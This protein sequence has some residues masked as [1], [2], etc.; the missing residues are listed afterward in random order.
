[1]LCSAPVALWS[2]PARS[3]A[4][5]SSTSASASTTTTSPGRCSAPAA[6]RFPSASMREPPGRARRSPMSRRPCVTPTGSSGAQ[7]RSSTSS[8]VSRKHG[9]TVAVTDELRPI[10]SDFNGGG[11]TV[12]VDWLRLSPYASSSSFESRVFDAGSTVGWQT[13]AWQAQTPQG[14]SLGLNVRAGDTATPDAHVE[15]LEAGRRLGRHHRPGRPL[16]PVPGGARDHR[17]RTEPRSSSR[18]PSRPARRRSTRRP[19]RP[20]TATRSRRTAR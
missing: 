2:S 20:T 14:T 15:R 8:T 7:P 19:P 12:S 18:S 13:L 16:R 4:R 9:I 6:A 11:T 1:M 3:A 17:L 5:V 10:A